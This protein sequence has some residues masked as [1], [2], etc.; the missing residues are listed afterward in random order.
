[1]RRKDAAPCADPVV[2]TFR[3][4]STPATEADLATLGEWSQRVSQ[5][6][7]AENL[8]CPPFSAFE[9]LLNEV[10]NADA[11]VDPLIQPENEAEQ[12]KARDL[13]AKASDFFVN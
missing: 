4:L 3:R 12:Q 7:P 2:D 11:S 1:M 5:R 8:Y 9:T 10:I 6:V 13:L